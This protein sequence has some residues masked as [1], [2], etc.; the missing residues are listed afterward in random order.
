MVFLAALLPAGAH[1]NHQLDLVYTTPA[2]DW[3]TESLPLGNGQFGALVLGGVAADRLRLS[4]PSHQDESGQ[5]QPFA[6]LVIRTGHDP[7]AA[8]TYLRRLDLQTAAVEISYRDGRIR[9]RREYFASFPDK[10]L[11]G[12]LRSVRKGTLNVR[13]GWECRHAGHAVRFENSQRRL[14]LTA[15]G[16]MA[17]VALRPEGGTMTFTQEEVRIEGADRLLLVLTMGTD[18]SRVNAVLDAVRMD[19][20]RELQQRHLGDYQDHFHAMYLTLEG[21]AKS[22]LATPKRMREYQAKPEE[23]PGF[24]ELLFQYG[25]YL[26]LAS[27]ERAES[28]MTVTSGRGIW[29]FPP[30]AAPLD[31]RP[32]PENVVSQ[33]HA[34]VSASQLPGLASAWQEEMPGE[35]DAIYGRLRQLLQTALEPN[36]MVRSQNL[37][38]NG[39]L[40]GDVCGLMAHERDGVLHWAT[41]LPQA[42]P[43]GSV[44]GLRTPQYE[45]AYVWQEGGF[46]EGY[47]TRL[48]TGP[49]A[50]ASVVPL[51]VDRPGG[52]ASQ[53]VAPDANGIVRF[54]ME[55]DVTY[56]LRNTE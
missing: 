5:R 51:M 28:P 53:T 10:V 13:L 23:D 19:D 8:R 6:D 40:V 16:Q 48:E 1:P 22:H 26:L 45:V 54:P 25:R 30:V 31:N 35:P 2:A 49:A 21:G 14:I 15:A 52:E 32:L 44:V 46:L 24:E 38:A 27:S 20:A 50:I 39:A 4:R 29:W 56:R 7:E 47:L 55:K 36:L 33:I 18:A 12:Q 34:G 9:H 41:T 37:V 17:T 43:D 42:W 11:V 3:Q